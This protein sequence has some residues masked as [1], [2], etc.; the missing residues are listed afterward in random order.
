M[1]FSIASLRVDSNSITKAYETKTVAIQPT[2]YEDRVTKKTKKETNKILKFDNNWSLAASKA[3]ENLEQQANEDGSRN[4]N[5][6]TTHQA[7]SAIDHNKQEDYHPR[8]EV[9]KLTRS[10]RVDNYRN[11]SKN[12]YFLRNRFKMITPP[13]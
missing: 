4:I 1:K 7:E 12:T 11:F 13:E 5:T 8:P 10:S 2:K 9:N 3:P 6:I